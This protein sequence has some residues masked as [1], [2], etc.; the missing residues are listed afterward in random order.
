SL[1]VAPWVGFTTWYYGSPVPNTVRAKSAGYL[2]NTEVP[3]RYPNFL[4]YAVAEIGE[5][6]G[7]V[8]SLIP[9]HFAGHGFSTIST[10]SCS[11]EV[12]ALLIWLGAM[13]AVALLRPRTWFIPV[14]LAGM[15]VFFVLV[16]RIIF[17]WYP[18]PLMGPAALLAASGIDV[19]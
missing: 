6:M 15:L 10:V 12:P 1:G 5:H 13:G 19:S 3:Y 14:L 11:R 8:R 2:H 9:P 4:S 16:V 7:T 18:P 17:P